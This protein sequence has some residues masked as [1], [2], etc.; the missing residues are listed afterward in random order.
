M[1]SLLT[2]ATLVALVTF[3]GCSVIVNSSI[4]GKGLG[5][6]CASD[7]DCH[8]GTC[9]SLEK[10][11]TTS[12]TNDAQCP[13]PS[14]CALT[15]KGGSCALPL[16]VGVLHVG[17]RADEGWTRTH[18]DGLATAS[19]QLGY[20][21]S[22]DG[23]PEADFEE[24]VSP[25]G[26]RKAYD[27]LR[28]KGA[29]VIVATSFSHLPEIREIADLS[30]GVKFLVCSGNETKPNVGSYF[31]RME[32]AWYVAGR[33]AARKATMRKRLGMI[34]SFIT[35]EVVRHINAFTLGARS[36]DAAIVVEVKWIGFWFDVNDRK[37][38]RILT[39][40]LIES[41]AEV[42]AHQGDTSTP[43]DEIDKHPDG[44]A[45]KVSSI[46]NDNQY[47]CR[48]GLTPSGTAYK[49]CLASV[50]WD[51]GP[52]YVRLLR[53]LHN[54]TWVPGIVNEPIAPKAN[55]S[56]VGIEINS[57]A[58]SKVD[59]LSVD[60]DIKSIVDGLQGPFRGPHEHTGQRTETGSG[61]LSDAE[62]RTM[63]WFVKGVV[64]K[65]TW[66]DPLS[67]DVDAKVPDEAN[68]PPPGVVL[69]PGAMSVPPAFYHCPKNI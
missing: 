68:P 23:K 46:G 43:V 4:D 48:A 28:A 61:P 22:F 39:K 41:G 6:R 58:A 51:W 64:Q 57:E 66:D 14:I 53:E 20:L 26:I 52:L 12:C 49:S 10:V 24:F 40:Q 16:R 62:L 21:R 59:G 54:G 3:S 69:P 9:D 30:P 37:R 33:M 44:I 2:L 1:K 36:V 5:A 29:N 42:I 13:A 18:F 27:S 65:A 8:A 19:K 63:C 31:G 67:A 38:E 17:G 60:T 55:G 32:D 25:G 11:C 45:G 47:G 50:Y 7:V 56:I 35:P 15:D 34:G